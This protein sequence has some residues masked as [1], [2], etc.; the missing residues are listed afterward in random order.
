MGAYCESASIRRKLDVANPFL[1]VAALRQ[2]LRALGCMWVCAIQPQH[3]ATLLLAPANATTEADSQ[4]RAV[5]TVIAR[6]SH[7]AQ[8]NGGYHAPRVGI[9]EA[10]ALI[11]T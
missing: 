1:R 10:K 4:H 11:V 8:G 5:R 3:A 6:A 2:L 7:S 9:V